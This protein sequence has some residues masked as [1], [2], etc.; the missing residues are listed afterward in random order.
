MPEPD[1]NGEI[2]YL[3]PPQTGLFHSKSPHTQVVFV[4]ILAVITESYFDK[5]YLVNEFTFKQNNNLTR[6]WVPASQVTSQQ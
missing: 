3:N 1:M 4:R 6:V 2:I 5:K